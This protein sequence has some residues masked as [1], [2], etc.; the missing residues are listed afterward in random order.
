MH[1]QNSFTVDDANQILTAAYSIRTNRAVTGAY[2]YLGAWNGGLDMRTVQTVGVTAGS[3]ASAIYAYAGQVCRILVNGNGPITMPAN[4]K[5]ADGSPVW[6]T[7]WTII[8][9]WCD[10]GTFWATTTPYNT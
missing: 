1:E 8:S 3:T 4:V 5:W 9:L 10:G 6:G 2:T 7:T